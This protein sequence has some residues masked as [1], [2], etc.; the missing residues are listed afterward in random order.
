MSELPADCLNEIFEHLEK[1]NV[2]LRSCLLV[3]RLWCGA[4]VRILWRNIRN[5]STLIACLPNE[6]KEILYENGI[7][8]STSASKPPIFNY[9]SFCK[10][11]SVDQ[12]TDKIN[13]LIKNQHSVSSQNVNNIIREIF[14]LLM[15]QISS[16]KKIEFNAPLNIPNFT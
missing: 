7:I 11:L 3:N 10:V 14:K 9:S 2:T 6:S 16:L 15:N 12:V 8:T 5:Y 1:D 13:K 4:S